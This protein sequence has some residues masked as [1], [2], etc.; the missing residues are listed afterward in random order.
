MVIHLDMEASIAMVDVEVKRRLGLQN[1]LTCMH[2][3]PL[4]LNKSVGTTL[5]NL[6][7]QLTEFE[8]LENEFES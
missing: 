6:G 4:C 8:N 5:C 3:V 2:L 7:C 1:N